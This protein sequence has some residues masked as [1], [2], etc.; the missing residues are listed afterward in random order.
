MKRNTKREN[1]M[2]N[3]NELAKAYNAQIE[4]TDSRIKVKVSGKYSFKSFTGCDRYFLAMDFIL[5]S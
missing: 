3:L 2:I 5:A 4:E 1:K